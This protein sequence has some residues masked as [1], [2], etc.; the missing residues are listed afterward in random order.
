MPKKK[1]TDSAVK[2]VD[3]SNDL[4]CFAENVNSFD[5]EMCMIECTNDVFGV[6]SH[7]FFVSNHFSRRYEIIG[8]K[9]LMYIEL[10]MREKKMDYDGRITLARNNPFLNSREEYTFKYDGKIHYNGGPFA[11][12]HFYDIIKGQATP[13]T[14]V[15]DAFAAEM[16]GLGAMK[17]SAENKTVDIVGD[18]VPKDLKK[19]FLKAYL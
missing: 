4:C 13:F 7:C 1:N 15:K 6:Y 10:S 14:T 2:D 8:D 12:R 16:V 5:N 19:Y 17:S 11:G 9:G 3:C 18:M